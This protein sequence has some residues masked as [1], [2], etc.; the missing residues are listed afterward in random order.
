MTIYVD[1]NISYRIACA[2]NCLSTQISRKLPF[3]LSVVALRESSFG[4]DAPD[5]TWIPQVAKDG[6][7]IFTQD[8]NVRRRD[9]QLELLRAHGTNIIY[10]RSSEATNGFWRMAKRSVSAWENVIALI[11]KHH[12]HSHN[13]IEVSLRDEVTWES[14]K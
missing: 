3:T 1:Q 2:L 13:A 12:K 10:L 11:V 4:A 9:Q 5:E 6:D 8:I 7:W 14:Y